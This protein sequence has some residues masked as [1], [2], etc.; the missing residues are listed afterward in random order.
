MKPQ[1]QYRSPSEITS[2]HILNRAAEVVLTWL[3]LEISASFFLPLKQGYINIKGK[4]L[5]VVHGCNKVNARQYG[6]SQRTV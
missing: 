4:L 6:A 5:R 3:T 1:H 2:V